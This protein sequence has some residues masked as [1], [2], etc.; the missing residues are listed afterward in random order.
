[1][2]NKL[3]GPNA[4]ISAD[5]SAQTRA[6][7][8]TAALAEEQEG[9]AAAQAREDLTPKT[10]ETGGYTPEQ[11]VYIN[12]MDGLKKEF[13]DAFDEIVT[14]S[15]D[16][17]LL[18][19]AIP[20]DQIPS[21]SGANIHDV[22][23]RIL[24]TPNGFASIGN[25]AFTKEGS[26]EFAKLLPHADFAKIDQDLKNKQ[27]L[28]FRRTE[29]LPVQIEAEKFYGQVP[30]NLDLWTKEMLVE[31]NKGKIRQELLNAI[32]LAADQEGK[33]VEASRPKSVTSKEILELFKNENRV[34]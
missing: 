31:P 25:A 26:E 16:R 13:P 9:M 28:D 21:L 22:T 5:Q 27:L 34:I 2:E 6:E 10:H 7:R 3:I 33:R 30:V 12:I 20:D 4:G 14:K 1:M 8:R 24:L 15:G 29:H 11:M 32:F 17:Y 18:T 23:R 19:K